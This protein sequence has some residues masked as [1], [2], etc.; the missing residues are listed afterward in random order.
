MASINGVLSDVRVAY[1]S[2]SP[3]TWLKFEQLSDVSIPTLVSDD[4]DTTTYGQAYKRSIPG[5]KTVENLVLTMLRD[6]KSSSSPNQNALFTLNASGAEQWWRIEIH[7][8]TDSDVN[9]WEAY[10]FQGRVGSF[11]PSAGIGDA[12]RL[13]SNIKFSG[14]SYVRYEPSVSEIG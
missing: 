11:E 3:Q 12:E 10:E 4:V 13:V 2:S 8:D 1:A 5:L 9:L 6:P 14:T 7:A